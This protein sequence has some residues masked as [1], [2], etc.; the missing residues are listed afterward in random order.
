M[1][2]KMEWLQLIDGSNPPIFFDLISD[3]SIAVMPDRTIA[4]SLKAINGGLSKKFSDSLSDD[5][6]HLQNSREL[7]KSIDG[8]YILQR[9]KTA[10]KNTV[11]STSYETI[12]AIAFERLIMKR[13]DAKKFGIFSAFCTH[14]YFTREQKCSESSILHL[15]EEQYTYE[16]STLPPDVLQACLN[17]QKLFLSETIWGPNVAMKAADAASILN[18]AIHKLT[19]KQCTIFTLMIGMHNCSLFLPF[20]VMFEVISYRK[21]LEWMTS[22]YQPDSEEEIFFQET[23]AYIELFDSLG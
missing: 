14:T 4:F 3:L 13:L 2:K 8:E 11:K 22:S 15:I 20:A 6:L 18:K 10:H 9:A 17:V 5:I 7:I 19:D 23:T 1:A 12:L 21:Y 16:P